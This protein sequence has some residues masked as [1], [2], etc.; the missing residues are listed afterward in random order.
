MSVQ[1]PAVKLPHIPL[2]TIRA[3][4]TIPGVGCTGGN[5]TT[6]VGEQFG[7]L[8]DLDAVRH[9]KEL[10]KYLEEQMQTLIEGYV[11]A[12]ERQPVWAARVAR[13]VERVSELL[14]SLNEIVSGVM[15]ETN[16]SMNFV[17]GK[18]GELNAA[19]AEALS[20]PE[21]TR[22]AVQRL[23]LERTNQYIAEL[24]QQMGRLESTIS[25]I[26]AL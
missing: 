4:P 6:L 12:A 14:E 13:Y 23:A 19:R 10:K 5:T 8:P 1:L 26:T 2:P 18:I 17:N 21:A 25:C 20:I 24:N 7:N 15:A 3:I 22:S 9:I 11:P 16:A